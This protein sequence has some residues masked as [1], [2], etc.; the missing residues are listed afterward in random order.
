MKISAQLSLVAAV[1]LR[2]K[3]PKDPPAV[4]VVVAEPESFRHPKAI[5]GHGEIAVF[6][7]VHNEQ[8]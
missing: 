7:L 1:V 8:Q 2:L 4:P 6:P 5:I 3:N